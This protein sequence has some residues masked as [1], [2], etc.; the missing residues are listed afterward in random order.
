MKVS[1]TFLCDVFVVITRTTIINIDEPLGMHCNMVAA[2]GCASD[3]VKRLV[4]HAT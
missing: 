1:E 4:R 2:V 3:C